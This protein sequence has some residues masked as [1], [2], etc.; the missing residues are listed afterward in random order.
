MTADIVTYHFRCVFDSRH[1][2]TSGVWVVG[3]L[4]TGTRSY[5]GLWLLLGCEVAH[6]VGRWGGPSERGH[7]G[8]K[9]TGRPAPEKSG[10]LETR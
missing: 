7:W 8:Y 6:V 10:Q 3:G 1:T 9:V 4:L 2:L 5:G